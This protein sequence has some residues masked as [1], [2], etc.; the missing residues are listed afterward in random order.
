MTGGN[1]GVWGGMFSTF[2][3]AIKGWRQKEDAWNAIASGFLTGGC[4][5]AR[6]MSFLSLSP[7]GGYGLLRSNVRRPEVCLRFS[8]GLRHS[9]GCIRGRWCLGFQDHERQHS[10]TTP[11]LTRKHAT[12]TVIIAFRLECRYRFLL[13]RIYTYSRLPLMHLYSFPVP[14]H[15]NGIGFLGWTLSRSASPIPRNQ[16]FVR[17]LDPVFRPDMWPGGVCTAATTG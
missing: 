1:F 15:L 2:D 11:S 8:S 4:L 3:C 17:Q 9:L 5:A 12:A 16:A 7:L 13:S 10:S 14:S 6:S